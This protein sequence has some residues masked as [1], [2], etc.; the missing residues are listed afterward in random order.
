M[1]PMRVRT[2]G[3][4]ALVVALMGFDWWIQQ[5]LN[6]WCRLFVMPSVLLEDRRGAFAARCCLEA[7][8]FIVASRHSL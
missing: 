6:S 8:V 5:E 2:E 1:D 7:L 3:S 4:A